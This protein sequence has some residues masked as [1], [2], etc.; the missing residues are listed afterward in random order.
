MINALNH[1]IDALNY[2]FD[3]QVAYGCDQEF[4][5]SKDGL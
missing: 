5:Y 2:I 3:I 4:L 1:K